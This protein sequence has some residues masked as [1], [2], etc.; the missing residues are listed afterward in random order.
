VCATSNSG[1]L[2]GD[3]HGNCS[4]AC[5]VNGKKVELSSKINLV[6]ELFIYLTMFFNDSLINVASVFQIYM[7]QQSQ[8][9]LMVRKV[10]S[11]QQNDNKEKYNI[12]VAML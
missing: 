10:L 6:S 3:K 2:N 4:S 9:H 7:P 11:Q 8:Q 5:P 1:T 12:E